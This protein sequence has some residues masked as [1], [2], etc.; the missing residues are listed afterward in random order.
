VIFLLYSGIVSQN[1][2]TL[3]QTFAIIAYIHPFTAITSE[4]VEAHSFTVLVFGLFVH[5]VVFLHHYSKCSCLF[6]YNLFAL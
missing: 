3:A 2:D 5:S 4:Y 6:I 1:V